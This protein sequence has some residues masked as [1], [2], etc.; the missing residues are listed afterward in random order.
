[1]YDLTG[2]VALVTGGGS[3]IGR[4]VALRLAQEGCPV[5]VI[6]LDEAGARET[7]AR[8]GALGGTAVSIRGD[9]SD[10]A[11]VTNA[12]RDLAGRLGGLDILFNGAGILRIA[13]VATMAPKDWSDTF[14]INVDGTFYATRAAL[15][16]MTQPGGR[17]INMASW[18]GKSGKAAYAAYCASKYAIIGLT[19]S[20]A[21]ELAEQGITVNAICPGIVA[22]TGMRERAEAD[23]KALGMDS[24][25]KRTAGIPLGRLG[26]PEDVANLAAFL[27]SDQ[28]SYM[29]GQA[30][31]LAGGMWRS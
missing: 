2:K 25:E 14:R 13:P 30:I 3:G 4:A 20:L 12:L 31:T 23:L 21:L 8:I 11:D 22:N 18:L 1:M 19:E 27:A 9:V 24:A 17:I 16:F 15:P 7:A 6:D 5:G 29:T 10:E 26:E 28:S